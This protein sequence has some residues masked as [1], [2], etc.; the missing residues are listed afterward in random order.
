MLKPIF[1]SAALASFDGT[2]I[3]YHTVGDFS[4][5]DD[6]PVI[7]LA[8]GLGGTY[9]AWRHQVAHL[10]DR[11]RFVSW[12]YRGLFASERPRDVRAFDVDAQVRDLFVVLDALHVGRA[13]MMGWSMGV[14]VCLEAVRRRRSLASEMVLLN[15][16]FGRPFAT[17]P[18]GV[19]AAQLVP[20]ILA[21]LR[22][23]HG[24]AS[25]TLR[26][27]A[28]WPQTIAWMRR[29][30]LVAPSLD[31]DVFAESVVAFGSMDL[32]AYFRTLEG[33]GDHD[34]MDVLPTIDVPT[35]VITGD[36][37]LLTPRRTAE[38]IARKI[39]G[40]QLYVIEGGTHYTAVEFPEL[41]NL[42]IDRF[43]REAQR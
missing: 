17:L 14:Q 27:V 31:E 20:K 28:G 1:D 8:N 26:R 36:R 9:S 4:G 32:D 33:L 29:I 15:G 41:V 6:R 16:T 5:R 19:V 13:V 39:P 40:A 42:R 38:G 35:L 22:R 34:A 18:L 24:V 11:Y 43:L 12:D 23:H 37:D 3:A 7:V 10:R 21:L 30:G 2:R 25:T